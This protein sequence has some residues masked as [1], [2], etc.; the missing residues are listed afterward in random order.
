MGFTTLRTKI[1]NF[2][3]FKQS[4]RDLGL[5]VKVDA[6]VRGSEGIKTRADIVA[7]LEGSCD[8]GWLRNGDGSYDIIADREGISQRHNSTELINSI[9]QKYAINK[10]LAYFGIL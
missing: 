7:V 5:N 9:N 8:I 6:D 4:L 2:E 3:I 10:T 1:T